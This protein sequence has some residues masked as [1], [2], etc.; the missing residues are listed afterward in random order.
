MIEERIQNLRLGTVPIVR[1]S[2]APQQQPP[3]VPTAAV[4][5]PPL[6]TPPFTRPPLEMPAGHRPIVCFDTETTGFSPAIVCQLAYVVVENGEVTTEYDQLLELPRGAT[7]GRQAQS[8]HGISNRACAKRGVDAAAALETFARMCARILSEGGRLVAHNSRFD[9]RA[10]RDTRSA[11]NL[12][13]YEDNETLTF[14]DTFCTMVNS[15]Q[16]SPLKD[17]AGRQKAFKNDEMFTFLYGEPPKFARLH[18]ALDDVH[19]TILCYVG[20][21]NRGWW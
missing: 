17:K 18:D 3:A 12:I 13:D 9:V 15:K 14:T 16:Y 6:P 5:P 1:P 19:V 4:P 21:V 20:G 2:P 8:I 10:I 7:I 11:H